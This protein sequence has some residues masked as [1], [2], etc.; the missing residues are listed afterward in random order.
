MTGRTHT[1]RRAQPLAPGDFLSARF[2]PVGE[3]PSNFARRRFVKHLAWGAGAL[4]AGAAYYAWQIEPHWVRITDVEL[5]LPGLGEGL[6]GYRL[7][8][9]HI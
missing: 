4:A 5:S 3:S 7:S 6:D 9:I 2:S 8:L 1:C